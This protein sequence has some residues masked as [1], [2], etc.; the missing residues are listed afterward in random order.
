M[1]GRSVTRHAG[2]EQ[3]GRQ[4]DEDPAGRQPARC[5]IRVFGGLRRQV[6]GGRGGGR[7]ARRRWGTGRAASGRCGGQVGVR[8]VRQCVQDVRRAV[9]V[10]DLPLD[11][12]LRQGDIAL[13][14][15]GGA[16]CHGHVL[17]LGRRGVMHYDESIELSLAAQVRGSPPRD[18]STYRVNLFGGRRATG[19]GGEDVDGSALSEP[20]HKLHMFPLFVFYLRATVGRS[21]RCRRPQ[22]AAQTVRRRAPLAPGG[23]AVPPNQRVLRYSL[24]RSWQAR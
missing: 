19:Q 24:P 9:E 4:Q 18:E 16:Q 1:S 6:G 2:C 7:C 3:S 23:Q 5:A 17:E 20:A 15:L 21:Q 14:P 8:S 22:C 10:R 12:V 11:V 13:D